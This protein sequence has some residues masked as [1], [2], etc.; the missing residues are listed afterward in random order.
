MSACTR[1]T[2]SQARSPRRLAELRQQLGGLGA[3][4]PRP[5]N[6]GRGRSR[7][8]RTGLPNRLPPSWVRAYTGSGS[9]HSQREAKAAE[10]TPPVPPWNGIRVPR[11]PNEDVMIVPRFR[12]TLKLVTRAWV[13]AEAWQR[14]KRRSFFIR[15]NNGTRAIEGALEIER[16]VAQ[17]WG[18]SQPAALAT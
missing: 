17:R 11:G 12:S 14:S 7:S 15:L 3:A 18:A 13:D 9:A 8:T 6:R 2:T 16:Y 5:A 1:S 10:P 4:R